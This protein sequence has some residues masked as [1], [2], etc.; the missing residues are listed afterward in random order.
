MKLEDA[1]NTEQ[2]HFIPVV[3]RHP[4]V[5]VEGRGARLRDADGREYLDLMAGW[6]VCC[7]G[8]SHPELVR[9]ISEQA[10]KLMQTTN[11]FYSLPQLEL[12]E[13]LSDL[14]NGALPHSFLVNSGTEAMDGVV[15][16]AHRATGR[17]RYV[18][19]HN[20]FHG[21]SLGALRLIGQA[22]HREPYAALL[23]ESDIVPFDDLDAAARAVTRDVA[24]FVVEP[25]Q[26]EGGV[27]VPTDGYLAGLREIC[28]ASGTL[29]VFDE[30]QTG[31]GRCGTPLGYQHEAVQPDIATL[32]KGLG[33]GFP[34]AAFLCTDAVAETVQIGDHGTTYGGNPLAAAA[35][36]TVLRILAQERLDQRAAELGAKLQGRL[37]DFQTRHT[38]LVETVRGR[39][40]LQG[41]VLRQADKAA[42]LPARALADGVVVNVTAGRVVR[43]FPALNIPEDDLFEGVD[44]V[45]ALLG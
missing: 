11:I 32:G 13:R 39:G 26:G 8:H 7:L 38:D 18:S 19:T 25:I 20:S 41:L 37:R 23:P 27:N 36:N 4:A 35:A 33:G 24:A 40:L 2:K 43:F 28:D 21:R 31:I 22:K 1:R 14:S 5:I 42:E 45:L 10:G 29:L 16:L 30:I 15:K 12:L 44:R 6:G 9:A 3:K 17:R 34:V